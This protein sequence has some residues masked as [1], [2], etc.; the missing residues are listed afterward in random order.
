MTVVC[1]VNSSIARLDPGL[2][3]FMKKKIWQNS[4]DHSREVKLCLKCCH[5]FL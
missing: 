3:V 4:E 2:L 5:V 1:P